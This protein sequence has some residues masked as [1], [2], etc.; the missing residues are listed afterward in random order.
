MNVFLIFFLSSGHYVLSCFL[1]LLVLYVNCVLAPGAVSL[2]K[3]SSGDPNSFEWRLV[4]C[5]W[6]E[7]D[8]LIFETLLPKAQGFCTLH[9]VLHM[10]NTQY[11]TKFILVVLNFSWSNIGMS[12]KQSSSSVFSSF[13]LHAIVPLFLSFSGL[14]NKFTFYLSINV[15]TEKQW[16]FLLRLLTECSNIGSWRKMC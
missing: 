5:S 10:R 1:Y 8:A 2:I 4:V 14:V 6:S 7:E 11:R 12:E 9:A 13:S 15:V 3:V 16:R